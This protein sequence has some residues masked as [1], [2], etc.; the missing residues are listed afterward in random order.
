ML[1]I[2]LVCTCIFS[3]Q[4]PISG[5]AGVW[6]PTAR[7]NVWFTWGG[8]RWKSMGGPVPLPASCSSH[9]GPAA[10][11]PQPPGSLGSLLPAALCRSSPGS[12][13]AGRTTLVEG[14]GMKMGSY[15]LVCL[16]FTCLCTLCY[17]EH[18]Y[19]FLRE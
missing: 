1:C 9:A 10:V 18:C 11:G 13:P 3:S 7:T 17:H 8:P 6:G 15:V 2:A 5:R 4:W 12:G 16:L 14:V 19:L